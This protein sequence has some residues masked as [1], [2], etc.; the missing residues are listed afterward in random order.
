[1]DANT[2]LLIANL[3]GV[4]MVLWRSAQKSQMPAAPAPDQGIHALNESVLQVLRELGALQ[5][6]TRRAAKV[7]KAQGTP[8]TV[9]RVIDARLA[10]L[11][12]MVANMAK[13][14]S[15]Q[16]LMAPTDM[17]QEIAE[18]GDTQT[19]L[20]TGGLRPVEI[21]WHRIGPPP[22]VMDYGGQRYI[23]HSEEARLDGSWE[24]QHVA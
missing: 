24:Y 6:E 4:G 9:D 1:M 23:R 19:L 18:L 2:V 21:S 16:P 20:L 17:G 8:V 13:P 22:A 10:S 3:V 14:E 7:G 5:L 12:K 11:H 15:L